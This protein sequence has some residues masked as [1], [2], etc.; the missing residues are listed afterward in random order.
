MSIGIGGYRDLPPGNLKKNTF[1]G[2]T[3][4]PG[5][6]EPGIET[7]SEPETPEEIEARKKHEDLREKATKWLGD[8]I[9]N[10]KMF[11]MPDWPPK[12][13][14]KEPK[15]KKELVLEIGKVSKNFPYYMLDDI[16]SALDKQ[17]IKL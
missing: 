17:R 9:K 15:L 4:A 2:N 1:G 7:K 8:F 14:L 16:L 11:G 5:E 12:E 13:I 10:T 6:D 3:R